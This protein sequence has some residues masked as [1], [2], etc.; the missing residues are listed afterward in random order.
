[1]IF[2]LD[3]VLQL[4]ISSTELAEPVLQTKS[5][6]FLKNVLITSFFLGIV[7]LKK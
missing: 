1:M 4:H 3:S 5:F 2:M 6:C 7:K